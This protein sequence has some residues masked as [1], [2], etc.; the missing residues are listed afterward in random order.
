MQVI[1]LLSKQQSDSQGCSVL[2]RCCI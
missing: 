2:F 1:S